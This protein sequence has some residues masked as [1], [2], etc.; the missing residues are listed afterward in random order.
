[1]PAKRKFISFE[2]L[3]KAVR[4]LGIKGRKE[5][6]RRYREIPNAPCAPDVIYKTKGWKGSSDFFGNAMFRRHG[7]SPVGFVSL[8]YRTWLNIHQRCYNPKNTN[9][10]HYGGATPP[11]RVCERWRASYENFLADVGRKPSPQH[12]LGRFGD[13]GDYEP[14]NCSWQ[15]RLQQAAEQ[16][17]K[18]GN[19]CGRGHGL[20]PENT[21][22]DSSGWRHCRTCT[23]AWWQTYER[24]PRIAA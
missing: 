18:R 21:Y 14:R 16:N 7:D 15:T 24:K 2:K 6:R 9:Y 19:K 11:V 3:K 10:I 5:Y 4:V 17:K 1:M 20:T 13:V 22:V 8:E 23:R 12:S